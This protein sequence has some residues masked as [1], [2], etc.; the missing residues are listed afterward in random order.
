MADGE[1]I[2][3]PPHH[4]AGVLPPL[5]SSIS[6]SKPLSAFVQGNRLNTCSPSTDISKVQE[7]EEGEISPLLA[8]AV[9]SVSFKPIKPFSYSNI[10]K[11][12]KNTLHVSEVSSVDPTSLCQDSLSLKPLS[13]FQGKPCVRFTSSEKRSLISNH[14]FVLVGKFSHGRPPF[15]T[16]KVFFAALKLQGRYNL[17]IFD[18]KHLFIE[19]ELK[20]DYVRVWLK[21]TWSIAGFAMRIFKWGSDFT[22]VKETAIAPVWIHIEGVPLYLFDKLSLLS[23]ANTIGQ[24][25]SVHPLNVNRVKLNS[26]LI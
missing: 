24:P 21:L 19:L 14:K 6:F 26:A 7:L 4:E 15:S 3:P 22:L 10:V 20:I 8:S 5:H 1:L 25:L 13:I 9:P 17:S 23:I 12:H 16:I 11:G 2:P 18:N